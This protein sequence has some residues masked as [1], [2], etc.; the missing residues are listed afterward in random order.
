MLIRIIK[1]LIGIAL[2]PVSVAVAIAFAGQLGH[3]QALQDSSAYFLRGASIY[4]IMHLVLYKPN[5]FYVLGHEVAHSLATFICGG[6]VKAF[7]VSRRGGGVLTTK[8]NFFIA[9]FPYFFPTYTIFFW[10][11]YSSVSLFRDVSRLTPYFLFLLGFSLVFHLV[12]TVNSLKIKQSDILKSG[13]LFSVS[14]ICVL[15]IVL[16]SFILSLIFKDFSFSAFF[17][18]SMQQAKDIYSGI[19]AYLFL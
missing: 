4:A 18:S 15:N 10:L 19:Y 1:V 11:S 16:V 2:L 13:Y 8:S 7:R 17:H 5:Y 3:I 9:L 6:Q 12:M 14:L